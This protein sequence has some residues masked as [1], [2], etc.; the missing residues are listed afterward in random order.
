MI[1]CKSTDASRAEIPRMGQQLHVMAAGVTLG[2]LGKWLH[3]DKSLAS[4]SNN[5]PD[6]FFVVAVIHDHI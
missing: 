5:D 4:D 3:G 1:G 6:S 2:P